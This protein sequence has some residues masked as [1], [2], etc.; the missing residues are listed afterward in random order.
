M[1]G[2]N[3][4]CTIV[5]VVENSNVPLK[6]FKITR[7]GATNRNFPGG[8]K[9]KLIPCEEIISCEHLHWCPY[10][11]QT[12]HLT[13]FN[14]RALMYRTI[15]YDGFRGVITGTR[16]GEQSMEYRV[17]FVNKARPQTWLSEKIMSD[18]LCVS[19]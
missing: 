11:N 8:M 4:K 12:E 6:H 3:F 5:D 16:Q 13:I 9:E 17:E 18:C 10:K 19:N 15:L 7:A 1:E 2:I 14:D